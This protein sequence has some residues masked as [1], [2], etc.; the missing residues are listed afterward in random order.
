MILILGLVV[1][2]TYYK[3]DTLL[4]IKSF[5]STKTLG[6]L[7]TQIKSKTNRKNIKKI[8]F[9]KDSKNIISFISNVDNTS[10]INTY[11][12]FSNEEVNMRLILK[13]I[14]FNIDYGI[15]KKITQNF[16]RSIIND[17]NFFVNKILFPYLYL[18]VILNILMIGNQTMNMISN[19]DEHSNMMMSIS[20]MRNL[21]KTSNSSNLSNSGIVQKD[22]LYKF[23]NPNVRLSNWVGSP[24]IFE[25]CY[26]IISY[27]INNSNYKKLGAVLPRGILLEGPP[28][29]GKTYLAKAIAT[30]TNSS[31]ITMSGSEFI[32]MYVGVGA[33][34]V[35]ELFKLARTN[36]PSI[37]FIDEIDAI[38]GKRSGGGLGGS[39][40]EHD[41]TLNQLLTEMDGFKDNSEIIVLAATNR[42]DT[43]DQ[44]LLRPGR[45]DRHIHISLPDKYSREQILKLY[46][47]EKKRK[48]P[49]INVTMIAELTDGFSGA[50]L[51]NLINEAAILAA[52]RG[53]ERITSTDL[54]NGMEK[55]VVGLER[56]IDDRSE[57]SK[58]RVSVHE[59]G[60]S[61]LT[62]Y[63]SKYFDLQ[64]ISIKST[65]NGAGGYTLMTPK[66]EFM[67]GGLLTKDL[68]LKK[69]IILLGGKAAES[70]WY[71]GEQVSFGATQD[72]KQTNQLARTM[73]EMYGMGSG[74]LE[75]FY[76]PNL[77][78][79]NNLISTHSEKTKELIDDEILKI[80]SNA[81]QQAKE[82]LEKN[83]LI[84]DE[85]VDKVLEKQV[86]YRNDLDFYYS[87]DLK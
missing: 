70:I 36:S 28:G 43:L 13:C 18:L 31:F 75:T 69:I 47:G 55:L 56:G 64:K 76:N 35:R 2:Y 72:L 41:Q 38:G 39:H 58:R 87:M 32:E 25:E 24:E 9:L 50:D 12:T 1:L 22:N 34:R 3:N 52:R 19:N 4:T 59:V 26:E 16:L 68:L 7:T 8:L 82:I 85:L 54:T 51:K 60:H 61:F 20:N 44:A 62:I 57:E 46:L 80:I 17:F 78:S 77:N 84:F 53:G 71:G 14:K 5:W 81:Y 48:E 33:F 73:V 83:R 27:Q 63:F 23:T 6:E 45:F 21:T 10:I 42:K 37:I 40:R 79:G 67:S 30:E 65:Y 86:L 74:E 29:V 15:G 11:K 49:G 66:S